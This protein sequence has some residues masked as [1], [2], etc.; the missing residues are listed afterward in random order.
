MINGG[1][2]G[3]GATREDGLQTGGSTLAFDRRDAAWRHPD[4][5][6]R[7]GNRREQHDHVTSVTSGSAT[8]EGSCFSLEEGFDP[9]QRLNGAVRNVGAPSAL[10]NRSPMENLP[11]VK[12]PLCG[13]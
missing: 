3:D 13:P 7:T 8:A 11:M 12:R 6:R 5:R 10:E 4:F 9:G 1:L 2:S